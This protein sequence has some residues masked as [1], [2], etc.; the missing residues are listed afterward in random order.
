MKVLKPGQFYVHQGHLL[1]VKRRT[2]GCKGCIYEDNILLC[3][4]VLTKYNQDTRPD[5]EYQQIVFVKV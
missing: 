1:R 5:C 2:N 4:N 3:P